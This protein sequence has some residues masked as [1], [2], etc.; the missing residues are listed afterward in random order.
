MSIQRKKSPDLSLLNHVSYAP[1]TAQAPAHER[2]QRSFCSRMQEGS[3]HGFAGLQ[4]HAADPE[5]RDGLIPHGFADVA[6]AVALLI[7]FTVIATSGIILL[8]G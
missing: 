4:H 3:G 6:M 7:I 5:Q 2:R 1:V 8:W